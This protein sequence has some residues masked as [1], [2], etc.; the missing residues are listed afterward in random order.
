M[1]DG[2]DGTAVTVPPSD[3]I[4]WE[5]HSIFRLP[6]LESKSFRVTIPILDWDWDWFLDEGVYHT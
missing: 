1:N 6:N 4:I 2:Y 3:S 5:P